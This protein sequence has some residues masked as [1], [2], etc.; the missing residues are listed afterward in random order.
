MKGTFLTL[1]SMHL[2]NPNNGDLYQV[3]SEGKETTN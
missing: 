2:N 3:K 1:V